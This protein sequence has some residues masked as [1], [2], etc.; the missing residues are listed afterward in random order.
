MMIYILMVVTF[1]SACGGGSQE[2][3]A[4]SL[5]TA[6]SVALELEVTGASV[7]PAEVY[8]SVIFGDAAQLT[9]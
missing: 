8:A 9:H 5:Y 2:S 3:D 6:K 4:A 1:I 7:T